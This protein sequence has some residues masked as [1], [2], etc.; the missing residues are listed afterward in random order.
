M[1]SEITFYELIQRVV[2]VANDQEGLAGN[3]VEE[4][5]FHNFQTN[6][7]FPGTRGTL[8]H[9]YF[10]PERTL[11]GFE[12]PLVQSRIL[13]LGPLRRGVSRLKN[14]ADNFRPRGRES[15]RSSSEIRNLESQG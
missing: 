11:Y 2:R 6:E 9:T 4:H 5:E 1:V 12:L 14:I 10:V 3:F 13:E 15:P 8:N 7:C